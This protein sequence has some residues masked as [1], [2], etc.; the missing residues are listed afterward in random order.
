MSNKDNINYL[1]VCCAPTLVRMLCTLCLILPLQGKKCF[2]VR[3]Q[4][5]TDVRQ[6]TQGHLAD[7]YKSST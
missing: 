3:K 2:Q 6:L 5:L 7:I 4:K 1:H